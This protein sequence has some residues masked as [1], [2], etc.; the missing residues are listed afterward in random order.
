MQYNRCNTEECDSGCSGPRD[1][2]FLI[3]QT[4]YMGSTFDDISKFFQDIITKIGIEPSRDTIRFS[5][6]LYNNH[7]I[8]YF[9][10]EMLSSLDEYNWAFGSIPKARGSSNYIG[11][12]MKYAT[13][14]M[15][16][17]GGSGRRK[18][19]PGIVVL[20]TDS[21]SSDEILDSV[22]SLK[23][24]VDRVLVVGLGYAYDAVELETIASYPS[25]DNFFEI[26]E[27]QEMT[28]SVAKIADKICETDVSSLN[29]LNLAETLALKNKIMT[30]LII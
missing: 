1:V 14:T 9:D 3:H 16:I 5:M 26:E 18:H 24:V 19:T 12:A 21:I 25:S 13:E 6:S 8:P 30:N 15:T 4:T 10:L 20:L 17:N 11:N 22:I 28:K 29:L 27:S 23:K 7:Y 2:L